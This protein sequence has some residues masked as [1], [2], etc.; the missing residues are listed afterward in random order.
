VRARIVSIEDITPDMIVKWNQWAAPNGHLISPYFRFEF[1]EVVSRA[2]SDVRVVVLEQDDELVG[3][4]P[5]HHP[6][7]GVVRPIGA[8]M[9]D[10]QGVIA[11]DYTDLDPAEIVRSTGASACIFENWYC[12]QGGDPSAR[13]GREGSVIV[14]L[15]AGAES[16]F[17][18]QRAVFKDHFKKTARRKRAAERDF[19]PVR[20]E[21]GDASGDR[22]EA[23]LDWKQ[24]Q[25]RQTQKLN[26]LGIDWVR[27]VLDDLRRREGQDF[28]GLTASLWFGD[29]LAAVEFGLVAGEVY[30]SWFPAYDPKMSK[31]SPGLLLLH[32]LFEQAH[33][34]D[35][36]RIDL[37]GGGG[38]HY[39]KYYS[40]YEVPLDHGRLLT[41][42]LG[43]AKVRTWEIAETA[44]GIMP[45]K[46]AEIP[47]RLR[48]RWSQA[49]AFEPQLFS[50]LG[51]MAASISL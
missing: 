27:T 13:R 35:L 39:K 44:A 46:I 34:R 4:F 41:G 21:L 8:P 40:S 6:Q 36:A 28:S 3:F 45:G 22:F 47:G 43:A 14:D 18:C 11:R 10:Y 24:T 29:T 19:G 38:A 5:H 23:L 26:V 2:R 32:G 9:S 25:Y 15:R 33:T 51:N 16:Y 48:R 1:A 49:C 37:G 30:H 31:Y 42:G 17:E 50:R 20:V 7:G 12:P